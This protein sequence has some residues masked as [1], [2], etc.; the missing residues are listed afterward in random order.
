M[1]PARVYVMMFTFFFLIMK[2]VYAHHR[3]FGISEI[4][5]GKK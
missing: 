4:H 5:E 2:V 1:T 3:Q